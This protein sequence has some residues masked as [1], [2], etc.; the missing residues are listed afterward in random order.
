MQPRSGD[1]GS[2]CCKGQMC[3][4]Q[5]FIVQTC[6]SG[7]GQSSDTQQHTW[8]PERA[9]AVQAEVPASSIFPSGFS[10]PPAPPPPSPHLELPSALRPLQTCRRV[11]C[12]GLAQRGEADS[13]GIRSDYFMVRYQ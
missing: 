7:R 4:V 13:G 6:L 3:Q 8:D 2:S 9:A 12:S 11:S 1:K 10:S 5:T